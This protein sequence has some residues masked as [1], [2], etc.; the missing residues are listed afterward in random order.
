MGLLEFAVAVLSILYMSWRE[1]PVRRFD[2]DECRA[3]VEPHVGWM[4][5]TRACEVAYSQISED[6]GRW[7]SYYLRQGRTFE[8][9][10]T[11]RINA[12]DEKT[13][14]GDG[15]ALTTWLAF[16]PQPAGKNEYYEALLKRA[17]AYCEAEG[18][19][20]GEGTRTRIKKRFRAM[21]KA[22]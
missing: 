2:W 20:C 7:R 10:P 8:H 12:D 18:P 19:A 6:E 15:F 1:N 3:L 21:S 22:K 11:P 16:D 17:H 9:V 4:H 5:A 14:F 13:P